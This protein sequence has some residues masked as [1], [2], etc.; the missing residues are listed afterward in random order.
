[1]KAFFLFTLLSIAV[2]SFACLNE[3]HVTKYGKE[4]IDG[5]SMHEVHFYKQHNKAVLE[6]YIQNLQKETPK[7]VEDVLAN[8]NSIAVSYIKLGRLEDAEK[9]LNALLKQYPA[10]YSITVNLG[11]LYE[12]QGK[13]QK[14]LDYIKK[15]ISINPESHGGSEWFHIRVLEFKLK[16]LPDSKITEQDILQIAAIKK[17]N[18]SIAY[19]IQYQLQERIPFTPAPNLIM[20]KILQEYADFLADSVSLKAAYIVY[21]MGMQYDENNALNLAAKRD[22]LKPYFKK[23]K[24][25]IPFTGNYYLDAAIQVADNNKAKIATS[26]L[27]KGLNYFNEQEEKRKQKARQQQYLIYGGIGVLIL[28]G[29]LFFYKRKKQSA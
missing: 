25:K 7:T 23:Y 6:E 20:A 11:T 24:E 21:E 5:F 13:N 29:S 3:H 28:I 9:I 27:E 12:L 14:A 8:Q 1:M 4:S 17:D 19:E 15:A 16:N 2:F 18:S 22:A 26:L 10:D